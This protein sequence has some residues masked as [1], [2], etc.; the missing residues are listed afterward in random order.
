[1]YRQSTSA[2]NPKESESERG[3][4]TML[5]GGLFLTSYFLLLPIFLSV[6]I[7]WAVYSLTMNTFYEA[8]WMA[9]ALLLFA[10]FLS[11]ALMRQKMEDDNGGMVVFALGIMALIAFAWMT[12]LDIL[13]TGTIYGGFMPK[14][15]SYTLLDY[16]LMLPGVGLLGMLAY[17]YFTLKHYG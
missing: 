2:V 6:L 14:P 10:T 17:K 9:P 1:L 8:P 16:I 3:M 5:L 7:Q 11:G 4:L 15:L 12:R 13:H